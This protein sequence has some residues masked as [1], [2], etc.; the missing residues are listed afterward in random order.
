MGFEVESKNAPAHLNQNST[1]HDG[2]GAAPS[3]RE[4][5]INRLLGNESDGSNPAQKQTQSDQPVTKPEDQAGVVKTEQ[6]HTDVTSKVE[7]PVETKDGS[8]SEAPESDTRD[9][10]AQQMAILARKEK[11]LRINNERS[12]S[13]IKELEAKL[14]AMEEAQNSKFVPKEKL[15]KEHIVDT[16]REAGLSYEDIT[17]AVLGAPKS[18]D[19]KANADF[20]AKV[21]AAIDKELEPIR[22]Q[23]EQARKEMEE[24]QQQAY[25]NA[26]NGLR[27]ETRRLVTT[28]D[29]FE[30]I[31]HEG[32]R[33]INEVV[34]LIE[35][36]FQNGLDEAR[37]KGT[38]MSVSEAAELI[39]EELVSRYK[40]AQGLK[41]LGGGKAPATEQES[42]PTQSS[43]DKTMKTLSNTTGTTPQMTPRERAIAAFEGRSL[44]E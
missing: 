20:E 1:P 17:A 5:A 38:I 25:E 44:K 15:S 36:T 23:Q 34:N 21:K 7:K 9:K 2:Q 33:A 12:S 32:D 4:R 8:G 13:K 28:D 41:K 10:Y 42:A 30:A 40:R 14:Q 26:L 43:G 31:A 29:N 6:N 37:P 18:E 3:A 35:H 19:I 11:A 16:L 39:E 27:A 22:K 24:G